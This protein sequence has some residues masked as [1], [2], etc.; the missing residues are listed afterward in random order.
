MRKRRLLT[1]EDL[2]FDESKG[3]LPVVVQ[4]SETL[5]VLTLA[6]ANREALRKTLETKYAHFFRRSHGRVMKKGETSGNV[7]KILDIWVDCDSDAVLYVVKPKGPACH[8]GEE[9]CFHCQ[10]ESKRSG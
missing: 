6:Y 7:Q 9:T 5:K 1:V 4:D 10:L 2:V 3:L 8:L